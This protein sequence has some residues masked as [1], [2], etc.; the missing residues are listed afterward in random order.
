MS[1]SDH[2]I[3]LQNMFETLTVRD[4]GIAGMKNDLWHSVASYILN[5]EIIIDKELQIVVGLPLGLRGF[6]VVEE[7]VALSDGQQLDFV[8]PRYIRWL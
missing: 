8:E 5:G 7:N 1:F 2:P 4:T 3:K 6:D